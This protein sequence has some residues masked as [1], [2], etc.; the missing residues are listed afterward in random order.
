MSNE[1]SN[2]RTVDG[3]PYR[4][5]ATGLPG[6]TPTVISVEGHGSFSL[7]RE[8]KCLTNPGM[9]LVEEPRVM[10]RYFNIYTARDGGFVLGSKSYASNAERLRMND[11]AR[12]LAGVKLTFDD[13][14]GDIRAER[15]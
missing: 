8:N 15:V 13:T 2:L 11:T 6:P 14:T 5:L 10:V 9:S 4:I 3:Y 12:A 1:F 7:D